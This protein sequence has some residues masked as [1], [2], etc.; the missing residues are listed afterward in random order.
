LPADKVVTKGMA[1][2]V[3]A[4]AVPGLFA[5]LPATK[6]SEDAVLEEAI[7]P[8]EAP[9]QD[10]P[11]VPL[12]KRILAESGAVVMATFWQTIRP[13]SFLFSIQRRRN[14]RQKMETARFALG[15]RAYEAG[16]GDKKVCTKIQALADRILNIEAVKGVTKEPVAERRALLLQLADATLLADEI[17]DPIEGEYRRAVVARQKLEVQEESLKGALGGLLPA[18]KIGWQRVAIGYG[19]TFGLL[20]LTLTI[21]WQVA[22]ANQL[23]KEQR[24]QQLAEEKRQDEARIAE[25]QRLEKQRADADKE[26]MREK[27]T[28][29]IVALCG[30]SVALIRFKEGK[31]AGGGTGFMIRPGIIATNAHVINSTMIDQL[32]VYFPSATKEEDRK[33]ALTAKLLYFDAKRDLAFLEVKDAKAPPLHLA[34]EFKFESGEKIT[35]IGCPGIGEKQLENAVSNGN[36]STKTEVSKQPYYQMDISVNPGNSGGPVFDSRGH[37]IGV[38]TLKSSKERI[39]FCIPWQDLSA[40][41]ATV[42]KPDSDKA[43]QAA[44]AQHSFHLVLGRLVRSMVLYL[45]TMNI[46]EQ[47]MQG[48]L[49]S[50]KSVEAGIQQGRIQVGAQGFVAMAQQMMNP[51]MRGLAEKL[52]SDTSLEEEARQTIADLWKIFEEL[53]DH[54]ENPRGT[55]N[56]Y[57]NKRRELEARLGRHLPTLGSVFGFEPP[58]VEQ[59]DS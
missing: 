29:E 32:K 56:S 2:P 19:V 23:A 17:P 16:F 6:S 12:W 42:A 14:L 24:E 21:Y 4:K 43:I 27:S 57:A 11:P 35:V 37:V 18:G 10:S 55:F 34:K 41:V 30:P 58:E 22:A 13:L 3:E 48:A 49:K 20:F 46:Y 51:K 25:Q 28:K 33:T 39:S 45:F 54:G 8:D 31:M 5:N 52:G 47:H 59:P 9:A 15:Q 50:G 44:N 38:V 26:L 40:G 1:K 53:R 36:L 7:A